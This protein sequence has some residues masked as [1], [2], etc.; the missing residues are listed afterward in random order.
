MFVANDWVAKQGCEWN[1]AVCCR[2]GVSVESAI[3]Y[4]VAD[5]VGRMG[6][7]RQGRLFGALR[8]LDVTATAIALDV[9]ATA[10]AL[11]VTAAAAIA[12]DM[13]VR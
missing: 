1:K 7:F 8:T 10:I 2:F 9:T 5:A 12:L 6:V 13:I 3:D 11:D 4:C